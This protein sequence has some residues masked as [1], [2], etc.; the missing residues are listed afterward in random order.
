M[1]KILTM[2]KYEVLKIMLFT[3][4]F[5]RVGNL[6]QIGKLHI[7]IK[8]STL[9]KIQFE[10]VQIFTLVVV[11]VPGVSASQE[12]P[13]EGEV[14]RGGDKKVVKILPSPLV[15]STFSPNMEV[16]KIFIKLKCFL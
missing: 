13:A 2:R 6:I 11:R 4:I 9:S 16:W 8:I 10:A 12:V 14:G 15:S 5:T 7:W 1:K 3:I